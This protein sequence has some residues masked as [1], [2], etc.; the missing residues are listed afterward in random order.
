MSNTNIHPTAALIHWPF[1]TPPAVRVTHIKTGPNPT[2][3]MAALEFERGRE[4]EVIA[5]LRQFADAQEGDIKRAHDLAH[6]QQ[7]PLEI[8]SSKTAVPT[9]PPSEK[10]V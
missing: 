6:R 10:N 9:A 2:D 8:L 1:S 7:L 5:W 4:K 3:L